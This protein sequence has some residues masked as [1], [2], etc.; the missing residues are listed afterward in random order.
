MK[1]KQMNALGYTALQVHLE[2]E[3]SC[4]EHKPSIFAKDL[5]VFKGPGSS[6][7]IGTFMTLPRERKSRK[8]GRERERERERES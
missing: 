4:R 7:G 1:V 6:T 3:W 5:W 8:G 2:K